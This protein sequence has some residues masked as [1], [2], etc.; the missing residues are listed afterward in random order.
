MKMNFPNNR[1]GNLIALFLASSLGFSLTSRAEVFTVT[2][3]AGNFD[4]GSLR[5]AIAAGEGRGALHSP[6]A[7]GGQAHARD[8]IGDQG[9]TPETDAPAIGRDRPVAE[10]RGAG[11]AE[12]S[13]RPEQQPEDR[14]LR[15]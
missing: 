1:R 13:C 8:A 12:L 6:A 11:V 2:N 10:K 7:L 14:S 4:E 5:S 9:E 15:R 3:T